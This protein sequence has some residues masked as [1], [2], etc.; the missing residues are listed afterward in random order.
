MGVVNYSVKPFFLSQAPAASEASSLRSMVSCTGQSSGRRAGRQGDSESALRNMVPRPAHAVHAHVQVDRSWWCRPG[1]SVP[2][3][4]PDA[5]GY[6]PH[7]RTCRLHTT[8]T[9]RTFTHGTHNYN[10]RHSR[11]HTRLC[12]APYR[13]PE[14]PTLPPLSPLPSPP[15]APSPLELIDAPDAGASSADRRRGP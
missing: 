13:P 11:L 15:P 2:S 8:L 1:H 6:H 3:H 5:G 12:A 9:P 4:G 7:S 14:R 10:S